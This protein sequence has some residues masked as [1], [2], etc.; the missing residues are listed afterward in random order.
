[1]KLPPTSNRSMLPKTRYSYF[2]PDHPAQTTFSFWVLIALAPFCFRQRSSSMSRSIGQPLADHAAKKNLGALEIFDAIGLAVV[3]A[4]IKFS[5]V[6]VQVVVGAVLI[7]ALHAAL[8]D[9]E[10]AFNGVG[11]DGAVKLGNVLAH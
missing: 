3:V 9:G 10:E 5:H 11:M 1:M 4:E 2:L 7:D 8:E 6:A